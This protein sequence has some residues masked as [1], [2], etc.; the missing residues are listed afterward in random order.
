MLAGAI[1]VIGFDAASRDSSLFGS[2]TIFQD[3]AAIGSVNSSVPT[4]PEPIA[5]S[6]TRAGLVPGE[7]VIETAGRTPAGQWRIGT[8]PMAPPPI[9]LDSMA[10]GVHELSLVE[11]DSVLWGVRIDLAPGG[12][13]H[14]V[15]PSLDSASSTSSAAATDSTRPCRPGIPPSRNSVYSCHSRPP[16]LIRHVPHHRFR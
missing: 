6:M 5:R 7:I 1:A 13:A 14:V 11:G 9:L 4:S 8:R 12:I 15:V 2:A 10:A 3:Q 16:S